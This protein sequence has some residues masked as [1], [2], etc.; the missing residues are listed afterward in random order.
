MITGRPP[1][2]TAAAEFDVPRSMP[3]VAIC[4]FRFFRRSQFAPRAAHRA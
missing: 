1:R 3:M 4:A 2:S